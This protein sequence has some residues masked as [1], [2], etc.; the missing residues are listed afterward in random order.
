MLMTRPGAAL[1]HRAA[2]D[3][4]AQ[5]EAM[6]EVEIDELLPGR[7]VGVL[8]SRTS[9]SRPPTI[10]DE[11]VDGPCFREDALAEVLAQ[12]GL[13]DIAGKV[14]ARRPRSRT[15]AAVACASFRVAPVQD[16]VGASLQP[17]RGAMTP[18]ETAAATSG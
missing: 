7:E 1:E 9:R 4:R 14:Q 3:L 16:D 10:V 11:D 17:P 15:S 12:G 13:G 8:A 5:S 18:A 2:D 6:G